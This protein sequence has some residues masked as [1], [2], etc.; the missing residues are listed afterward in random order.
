MEAGRGRREAAMQKRQTDREADNIQNQEIGR[1]L[2]R[3]GKW[4]RGSR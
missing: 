4:R 3:E 1:L 2:N